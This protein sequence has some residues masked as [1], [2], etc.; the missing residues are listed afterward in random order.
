MPHDNFWD[1]VSRNVNIY[2]SD[3]A[4]TTASSIML[5]DGPTDVLFAGTGWDASSRFMSPAQ[6]CTTT[7]AVT[8]SVGISESHSTSHFR[9]RWLSEQM[10]C[11]VNHWVRF[12]LG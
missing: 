1:L 8:A 10:V 6:A 2:R 9:G 5:E 11:P 3:P 7:A 12:L 4:G